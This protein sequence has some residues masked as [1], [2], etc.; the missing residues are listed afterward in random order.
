MIPECLFNVSIVMR[1]LSICL[2]N[3]T[4]AILIP[5]QTKVLIW[6]VIEKFYY[7]NFYKPVDMYCIKVIS[8]IFWLRL[9]YDIYQNI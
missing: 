6:S 2:K 4:P 1:S 5:Y 7:L 9:I 8:E 3:A